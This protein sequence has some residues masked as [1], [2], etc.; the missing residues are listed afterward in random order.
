MGN[1]IQRRFE[2]GGNAAKYI[3]KIGMDFFS[4]WIKMTN[5]LF[6]IFRKLVICFCWEA[7]AG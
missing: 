4:T 1:R 7:F 3:D 6:T 5:F 2:E